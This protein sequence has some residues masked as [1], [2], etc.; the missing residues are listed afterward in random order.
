M[1]VYSNLCPEQT[2]TTAIFGHAR[3]FLR[4]DTEADFI[5]HICMK[6]NSVEEHRYE[7]A[8]A[9]S[10][11]IYYLGIQHMQYLEVQRFCYD[12]GFRYDRNVS[13]RMNLTFGYVDYYSIEILSRNMYLSTHS[14]DSTTYAI[15]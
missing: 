4:V 5:R 3:V 11:N 7:F 2:K 15:L 10:V 6:W 1:V 8:K 14:L 9:P 12:K 13:N